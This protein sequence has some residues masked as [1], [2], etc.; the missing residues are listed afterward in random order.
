MLIFPHQVIS[1]VFE[2]INLED[3]LSATDDDVNNFP[4]CIC[5]EDLGGEMI[6]WTA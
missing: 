1:K 6:F 5:K 4:W 2:S 3:I